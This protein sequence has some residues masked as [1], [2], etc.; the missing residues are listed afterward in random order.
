MI[1]T[2]SLS[3]LMEGDILL[4]RS[5]WLFGWWI[6]FFEAL[7]RLKMKYLFIAFTHQAGMLYDREC[8]CI[9]RF[10]AQEGHKTDFRSRVGQA[11]VFRWKV[12]PTARQMMLY[13]EYLLKRRGSSY[14]RLAVASYLYN[15][16][17]ENPFDDICSE[18]QTNAWIYSSYLREG[19][20]LSPFG[21]Y[22]KY[23]KKI[24]FLWVII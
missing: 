12:P 2:L 16:I 1:N 20:K 15:R 21:F 3:E 4:Y 22:L 8:D 7:S 13:R 14:D 10:D 19:K 18:A 23:R 5:H 6:R 9:S 24:D 11:Y 17:S